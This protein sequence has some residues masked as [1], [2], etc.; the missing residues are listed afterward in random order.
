MPPWDPAP[1]TFC[2]VAPPAEPWLPLPTLPREPAPGIPAQQASRPL[3]RLTGSFPASSWG[4]F[5]SKSGRLLSV[6]KEDKVRE[7]GRRFFP[8]YSCSSPHKCSRC[9]AGN[10]NVSLRFD[11]WTWKTPLSHL[12]LM[13]WGLCMKSYVF[14]VCTGGLPTWGLKQSP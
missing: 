4:R 8:L 2:R 12:Y 5:H 3:L 9:T 11:S 13:T 7:K 6:L 1:W 10:R 14:K